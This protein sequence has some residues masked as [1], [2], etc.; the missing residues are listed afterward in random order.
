MATLC[1]GVPLFV[2]SI[3][4]SPR[5]IPFLTADFWKGYPN[6]RAEDIADFLALLRRGHPIEIVKAPP[7]M[8]V[9]TFEKQHQ[10]AEF[11]KS[12]AYLRRH[13]GAGRK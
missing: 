11:E 9:K 13:C 1:P 12:I 10:R 2:E 3:S 6:L 8:D 4:N 7:G 5:P